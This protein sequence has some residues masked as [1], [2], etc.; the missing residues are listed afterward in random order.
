MENRLGF[1]EGVGY[2]EATHLFWSKA[3]LVDKNIQCSLYVVDSSRLQ[4][5][6][7]R[8]LDIFTDTQTGMKATARPPGVC[9]YKWNIIY[10][11]ISAC[12]IQNHLFIVQINVNFAHVRIERYHRR[13]SSCIASARNKSIET[14]CKEQIADTQGRVF[15]GLANRKLIDVDMERWVVR[16]R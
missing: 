3:L 9:T 2:I 1:H 12:S 14:G 16:L 13:V 6:P 8:P 5:A 4:I 15:D 7:W 10:L 11:C